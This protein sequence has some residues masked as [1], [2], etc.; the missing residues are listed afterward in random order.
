LYGFRQDNGLLKSRWFDDDER[1]SDVDIDP[2]FPG[3]PHKIKMVTA[4]FLGNRSTSLR[5]WVEVGAIPDLASYLTGLWR[6]CAASRW[7]I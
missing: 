7:L 5:E 2:S 4:D 6:F 3:E 1:P